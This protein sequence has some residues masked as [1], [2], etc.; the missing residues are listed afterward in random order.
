MLSHRNTQLQMQRLLWS[1]DWPHMGA[2]FELA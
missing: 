2:L 1:L